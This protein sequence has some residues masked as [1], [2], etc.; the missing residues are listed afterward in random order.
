MTREELINNLGTIARSGTKES[1]ENGASDQSALIGQ[2]GVGFYSSFVVAD[3]IE[4]FTRSADAGEKGWKW[5]R[6]I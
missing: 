3:K 6:S 4:V 5:V 1:I 2:F